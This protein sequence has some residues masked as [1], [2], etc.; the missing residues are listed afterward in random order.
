VASGSRPARWRL[1]RTSVMSVSG[2]S[3]AAIPQQVQDGQIG[4]RTPV[5]QALPFRIPDTLPGEALAKLVEEPRF[6]QARRPHQTHDLAPAGLDLL[7]YGVQQ[8]QF[9]LPPH[10]R[11]MG[12]TPTSD[13]RHAPWAHPHDGIPTQ[14]RGVTGM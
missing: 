7:E 9:P 10:K 8:H 2:R 14:A 12:G 5:R 6:A 4:C 11:A 1:A 3:S 13:P